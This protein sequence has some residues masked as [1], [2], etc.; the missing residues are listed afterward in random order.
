[1]VHV[2]V[3]EQTWSNFKAECAVAIKDDPAYNNLLHDV[4][5]QARIAYAPKSK[6][7]LKSKLSDY[8]D[9]VI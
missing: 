3:I 7:K 6:A 8:G 2:L 9:E 4:W 5:D 1:M